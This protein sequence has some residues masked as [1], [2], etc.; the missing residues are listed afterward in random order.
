MRANSLKRRQVA[1]VS[2]SEIDAVNVKVFIAIAVLQIKQCA[3]VFG[4]EI[5]ADAAFLIG[6]DDLVVV[7]PDRFDPHLQNVVGIGRQ[8]R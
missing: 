8:P 5:L 1:Y 6:R 2:R 7:F 4:P 3:I